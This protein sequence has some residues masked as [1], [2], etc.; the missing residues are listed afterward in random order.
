MAG[1]GLGGFSSHAKGHGLR[2]FVLKRSQELGDQD[3]GPMSK[4]RRVS[5]VQASRVPLV[6]ADVVE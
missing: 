3:V 1:Y 4:L 6:A 5:H 2:P